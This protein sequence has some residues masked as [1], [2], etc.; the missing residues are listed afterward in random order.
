[1]GIRQTAPQ[2]G[3]ARLHGIDRRLLRQRGH[4]V[5]LESDAGRTPRPA[6]VADPRRA[7]ERDLRIPRDLPQ[8]SASTLR[9]RDAHTRRVRNASI[10]NNRGMRIQPADS[11]EPKAPQSLRGSQ[12]TSPSGLVD[13]LDGGVVA[14]VDLLE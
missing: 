1:M 7:G 12:S 10:T 5:V 11:T 9:A 6:T 14:E 4:R 8:P 13:E 2:R 3:T